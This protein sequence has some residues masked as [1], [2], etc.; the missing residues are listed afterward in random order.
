MESLPLSQKRIF[1]ALTPP[2][3]IKSSKSLSAVVFPLTFADVDDPVD[4]DVVD[5]D[6]DDVAVVPLIFIFLLCVHL[7]SCI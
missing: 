6:E 1:T 3:S 2:K 7:I 5:V 4:D